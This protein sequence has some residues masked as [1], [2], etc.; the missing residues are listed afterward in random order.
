MRIFRPLLLRYGR[1]ALTRCIPTAD[2]A[3][4]PFYRAGA[5]FRTRL[6]GPDERGERLTISG[7]VLG[8]P[9]CRPLPGAVL[10]VWHADARGLY[11]N[12]L[13][14]GDPNDPATFRLRGSLHTGEDGRYR[15]ETVLPGHYPLPLFTRARHI[16]VV[17]TYPEYPPLVTQIFFQGDRYLAIDPWAKD[18]LAIALT[19]DTTAQQDLGWAGRFD[20]VLGQR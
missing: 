9:D 16:H 7:Q 5:P 2:A 14:L 12:M 6:A 11:S 15:L 8:L 19:R 10:D 20:T 1:A 3:R 18:E 13:G 4:G 17:V